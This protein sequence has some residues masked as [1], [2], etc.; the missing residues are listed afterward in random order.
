M[1]FPEIIYYHRALLCGAS[2]VTSDLVASR[3]EASM[4]DWTLNRNPCF[5]LD[6]VTSNGGLPYPIPLTLQ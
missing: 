2:G 1:V 6:L 5:Q 4:E 3:N